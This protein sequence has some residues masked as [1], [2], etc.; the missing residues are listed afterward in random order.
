[1]TDNILKV[2][3]IIP[4][5]GRE[6]VLLETI[7]Q[8]L[9]Q[10]PAAAEILVIDQT[11]RHNP[12]TEEQL[13]EW[14]RQQSIRWLRLEKPS[15][16][17]A[18]NKGLS[19]ASYPVVLFVDDDIV[20]A[21]ELLGAHVASYKDPSIWAV[22]GQV[23][24]QGQN[25]RDI[26]YNNVSGIRACMDFPFNST[27]TGFIQSV[28]AGNLSVLR[29]KAVEIGGFDENFIGVAYRF[30][31]EFARRIMRHGG[32]ILYQPKASIQHLRVEYGGTRASGGH[33]AS[34]SPR[35]GVG[36]YYFAL[37]QGLNPETISYIFRRP[38]REVRTKFHLSHPWWIPIKF[39]GEL[40]A[41][42]LA[43]KLYRCGS[44]CILKPDN[45]GL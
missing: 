5:Y 37:H 6:K 35:H 18:M 31:T 44:R 23:L 21:P 4:T 2:S 11:L 7:C 38:F 19:E 15:I 26:N 36:D 32:K 22:T 34:I 3:L 9:Q 14:D 45:S 10:E 39:I 30:E 24:Q 1:M 40:R 43:I 42:F 29:E 16:T 17:G 25:A 20:P 28:M 27:K 33:M 12:A 41:L 8:L 13:E